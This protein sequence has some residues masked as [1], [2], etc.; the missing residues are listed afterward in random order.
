MPTDDEFKKSA[1]PFE[2]QIDREINQFRAENHVSK[3][4]CKKLINLTPHAIRFVKGYHPDEERVLPN[5]GVLRVREVFTEIG[6]I[7]PDN[8]DFPEIAVYTSECFAVDNE[9]NK[10]ELPPKLPDTCYVV[11]SKVKACYPER[12]D[13]LVPAWQMIDGKNHVVGCMGLKE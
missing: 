9:L 1:L 4:N 8:I 6:E 12:K 13:F 11:S 3:I 2:S 5:A 10:I 7:H